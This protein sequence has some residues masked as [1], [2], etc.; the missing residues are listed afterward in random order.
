MAKL[1]TFER[2]M[3]RTRAIIETAKKRA[4]AKKKSLPKTKKVGTS[5]GKDQQN[6]IVQGKKKPT[7]AQK[8][9]DE[10]LRKERQDKDS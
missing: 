4:K 3:R 8:R 10:K 6:I 5:A 2:L 1:Q 9:K 7:K